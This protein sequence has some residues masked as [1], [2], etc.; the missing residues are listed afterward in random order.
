[1][2]LLVTLRRN[3]LSWIG[4]ALLAAIV[5][6]AVFAPLLAPVDP[7]KQ[8]IIH[9]LEPPSAEFLLGTDSYGRD[10]LSRIIY[11]GRVSL[12]IGFVS[13]AVAMIIGSTLAILAGYIGGM[14]DHLGL[15]LEIGRSTV[16]ERVC[17]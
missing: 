6:M 1:M 17:Q 15:G 5:L 7:I 14:F 16:G 12:L 11:A 13:V 2:A 10:V 3:K 9:R 8:N 4:I